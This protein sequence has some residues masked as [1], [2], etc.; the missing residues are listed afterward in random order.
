MFGMNWV[1]RSRSSTGVIGQ[2]R[3]LKE[4]DVVLST[5][6]V[7]A[8]SAQKPLVDGLFE[9]NRLLG[10]SD[11]VGTAL[12]CTKAQPASGIEY[13]VGLGIR[14][15]ASSAPRGHWLLKEFLLSVSCRWF[16]YLFENRR[17][18][19]CP[20]F[21]VGKGEAPVSVI[22]VLD[23]AG[24][25]AHILTILPP[26]ELKNRIF[27]IEGERISLNARAAV[28][29]LGGACRQDPGRDGEIK[30]MILGPTDTGAAST[31]WDAV[32]KRERTGSNAA[33]SANELWAGHQWK[34]MKEV[35]NL[36]KAVLLIE[37]ISRT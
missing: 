7:L 34:T 9:P 6:Y 30:T 26:S 20:K 18:S 2:L 25:V 12:A 15:F 5:V 33:G 4:H 29:H 8:V 27:R 17:H 37:F 36:I 14:C 19:V 1:I 22:S 32:N 11:S 28:Q 23:L 31:G 3:V 13:F 21:L 16:K 24:F 10:N 35:H